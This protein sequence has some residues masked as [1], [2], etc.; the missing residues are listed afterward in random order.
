MWD[1][2][3]GDDRCECGHTRDEHDRG[4][5]ILCVRCVTFE[6]VDEEDE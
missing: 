4:G 2:D 1:N 3:D 5:C 6:L